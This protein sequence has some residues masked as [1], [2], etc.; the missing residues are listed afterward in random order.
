MATDFSIL[1]MNLSS[2][3]CCCYFVF[4]SGLLCASFA[5]YCI[6]FWVTGMAV[7]IWA[8]GFLNWLLDT[9]LDEMITTLLLGSLGSL[10][11]TSSACLPVGL[12]LLKGLGSAF[13]YG[14]VWLSLGLTFASLFSCKALGGSLAYWMV[15]ALKTEPGFGFL[16][17][18]T[19]FWTDGICSLGCPFVGFWFWPLSLMDVTGFYFSFYWV[20]GIWVREGSLLETT[21]GVEGFGARC[22]AITVWWGLLTFSAWV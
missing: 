13:N 5:G 12:P 14:V 18:V 8:G 7:L 16:E 6:G 4:D 10:L 11:F 19:S 2:V 3:L 22:G 9:L 17:E 15:A 21:I 20:I 1:S